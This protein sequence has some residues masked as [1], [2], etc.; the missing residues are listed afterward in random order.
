[1]HAR[2]VLGSAFQKSPSLD[3]K[4]AISAWLGLWEAPEQSVQTP[5]ATLVDED[6]PPAAGY[7]RHW[8][9]TG[10]Q[11]SPSGPGPGRDREGDGRSRQGKPPGA[12]GG[13]PL[14]LRLREK[15]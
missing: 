7:G 5:R 12:S 1:M 4:R 13:P 15:A 10:Q 14:D 11:P 2:S 6:P 8:G 9:T 3:R